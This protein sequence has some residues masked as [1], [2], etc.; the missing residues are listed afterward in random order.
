LGKSTGTQSPAAACDRFIAGTLAL[1]LEVTRSGRKI[2]HM[3]AVFGKET[4]SWSGGRGIGK[5]LAELDDFAGRA[6][7]VLGHNVF[8]HDLAILKGTAPGLALLK[9]P[10]VDTL[11]LS[12]LAFP[13]NPYHRLVK[14]YKLVRAS[15]SDPLED[16]RLALSVFRDQWES[17]ARQAGKTPDLLAF[18]AHCFRRSRFDGFSGR[19]LAALFDLIGPQTRLEAGEAAGVFTRLVEDLVCRHAVASALAD[20]AESTTMRP[21]LAYGLA[22]LRVAGSNSVLPPWVRHQ[23]PDLVPFL[24][25]LRDTPCGQADCGYCRRTHDPE[26]QL[27]RFFG[28]EGFRSEPRT[29]EGRSLQRAVTLQGLQDK[30]LL[31]ILPT[32][33]GKSLCF[34][35]PALVRHQ[36]R[37]LLTVVLSP[38]QAL[39]KD[40]VDNLVRNTGTPFAAAI[41]GLLTPPERGEVIERVRLGDIAILY[42]S[43]E[44]LRNRSVREVLTQREIGCWVFDEAH[45][46]SKWGHD[47]RPD[48]LYAAR[49]IREF[50][51]AQNLSL[52]PIACYTATAKLDVIEE[53][54]AYF[55]TE[56]GQT[57]V[58][59][60]GGVE[61]DNLVFDILPVNAAEK[62][63][64]ALELVQQQLAEADGGGIIVYAARRRTTEEIAEFFNHKGVPAEAFHAGLEAN[65]KRRIIEAFVSGEIPVICATNAFGMG[66]DKSDIRLVLHHDI[67]GSLENYLQEAGRAGR[68]LKPARCVLLYDTNDAETQF[69][70]GA[71]SEINKEEIRRIL[72]CLRRGKRNRDNQ[73]VLTT[74]EL[75]REDEMAG[76]FEKN[77]RASDT[78]VKTA[79]SW[80]ERADFLQRDQNLTQVFQGRPL[81]RNLEEADP[82]IQRLKL[83]PMM[84]DLWRG[85]LQVVINAPAERGL[86]ADDIAESLFSSAETLKRLEA[87]F[88]LQPSQLVIYAMHEMASAGILDKGMMLSA[89]VARKGGDKSVS[90]L[91]QVCAL[92]T[93]MLKFMQEQAPDAQVGDWLDLDISRLNQRL[94]NND[95][96]SN[97]LILRNLVKGLA[98][99]GKGLAGSHGSIDLHHLGRNRYRVCLQ[100]SWQA[101]ADTAALRRD[102]AGVILD[103]LVDKAKEMAATAEKGAPNEL[104]VPFS[105]NDLAAAIRHDITLQ[106]NVQK[107]LAA[108]DR[109]LM[110]LHEHKVITLQNGLAVFRQ[111]MTISLNPAAKGR[112]YTSGDFKPLAVHYRERRFQVHVIMEYAHLAME[113]IARALS[114]VLDYFALPRNRFVA[115]Y[116]ADRRQMLERATGVE[117][118]R[119]IVESLHNPVQ[120]QIVGSPVSANKLIMAGPGAGKSRVIVHRCAYLLRVERI[121]ANRILV[122]CF[123][124]H[125][126]VSLRKRLAELVGPDARGVAVATYHGA[127][128]R[129]A[130]ISLRELTEHQ[131]AEDL[132]FDLL[133]R[134]AVPLLKGEKEVPGLDPDEVREQLLQGFSHILVDEYQDIDQDQYELVSAIAGRTLAAE[135]GRLAIVAV[136]DDDQ[137][138]YAF[139]GANVRFIQRF[140]QDYQVEAIDY[141]VEN[142]RSSGHIIRAANQLV[143]RN[144]DRMKGEH[145]IRVNRQR[146]GDPEGGAWESLDSLARGRVQ[147]LNVKDPAHQAAAVFQELMRLSTLT[148]DFDWNR[149]TVLARTNRAL[150]PLRVLCEQNGIGFRRSLQSSLPLHRLRGVHQYL[151]AL[152]PVEGEIRRASEL[153]ELLPVGEA[154]AA[155][156]PWAALLIE[157]QAAYQAETVDAPLPVSHL[158]DWLYETLA[159]QRREK[160]IGRG[161]FLNTLHGAKGLEFDHVFIL[162]GDW[163]RPAERRKQE[164][165]RR[166]LYVGMTRARQTLCL[167]EMAASP[168]PFLGPLT[169][170]SILRRPGSPAEAPLPNDLFRYYQVLGLQE[171][172]LS[173]AAAFSP[174]HE[175]HAHLAN[176]AVGDLLT[177]AENETGVLIKDRS[178]IA[179]AKLSK[180]GCRNWAARLEDILEARVLGMLHWCAEDGHDLY[181]AYAKARTWELPLVEV[182]LRDRDSAGEAEQ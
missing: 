36:R 113:R 66:I 148:P 50:S 72:R 165:E 57:L 93:A 86:S 84:R 150:A 85:I 27:K 164:E 7:Y 118:Y 172:H 51:R 42:L 132:D 91:A 15:V 81:V 116:F 1:D 174:E 103:E 133:I 170:P 146:K 38:L 158:V 163:R 46:L 179:V 180:L 76:V 137:N 160:T 64:R 181:R 12:P 117:S 35:L 101:I 157:L 60:E 104:L 22:W 106:A 23:F 26:G 31:A 20:A 56:L 99:D 63:G 90:R 111:A 92:E 110:F 75:L 19:G 67:P 119:R 58:L 151:E 156:D 115:K 21:V 121:P 10:V 89:F 9:K 52:P 74:R 94:R 112:R 128:M 153:A 97:P 78:K 18:Y 17:F 25:R 62:P 134:E 182:V 80:L 108:I 129:L 3:A 14:D 175:I 24:R 122:L 45:C 130:G 88:G 68:D 144:R 69:R 33:G 169:G 100:R 4:F 49:F 40:Q 107:P 32:G 71:V 178:G 77:D 147:I 139:R 39:M 142:Y 16:A 136:G 44:Q 143:A 41:Y 149:C 59:Y 54:L 140:Q 48:Y 55:S 166:L 65:E 141:L 53:I 161:L 28:F 177:L 105:A 152:K 98:Y 124:H 47:F 70:L 167:M 79:V 131:G 145:P 155:A 114:L 83:S 11:Y 95:H 135:D 126:A 13:R 123:N 82:I 6:R 154:D 159:E 138:I 29:G 34:Q 109:G 176:L 168:N 30:P 73:I 61:R 43:P 120:I 171:V 37:G 2:R 173:Y 127:A 162:D 102:V 5:A 8:R 96:D 125:A 87:R